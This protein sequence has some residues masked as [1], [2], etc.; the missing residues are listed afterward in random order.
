MHVRV[1]CGTPGLTAGM[2]LVCTYVHC[3]LKFIYVYY[4]LEML[5][6]I[7][8]CLLLSRNAYYYPDMS[9]TI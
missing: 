3:T 4:Y 8:I 5:T 1:Y 7:Q 2:I 9:T 6:S